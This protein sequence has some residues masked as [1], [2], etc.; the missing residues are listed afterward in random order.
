MTVLT[1]P[2]HDAA[3]G[4]HSAWRR[5]R[6]WILVAAGLAVVVLLAIG[7]SYFRAY[8]AY[9][10]IRAEAQQLNAVRADLAKAKVPPAIL[11][12]E[13]ASSQAQAQAATSGLPLSL[14]AD[15]PFL[16]RP[17]RAM[18]LA[19]DAAGNDLRAASIVRATVAELLGQSRARHGGPAIFGNGAVN[20]R[21]VASVSSG[22]SHALSYLRVARADLGQ[23]GT[24]PFVAR[25]G[26]L[27]A[28]ALAD[29]AHAIAV[30]ERMQAASRLVPYLLG[31]PHPRTYFVALQNSSD[32]RGTGGA[33][34]AY[35]LMRVTNGR[36]RLIRSG[37]TGG[38]RRAVN[39]ASISLPS[40]LGWYVTAARIQPEFNDGVNYSPNFPDVAATWARMLHRAWGLRVDG[41][42]A[43][44]PLGVSYALG[45]EPALRVPA[46]GKRLPVSELPRVVESQQYQ[47][48]EPVQA[49]L[50]AELMASVVS[51]LS[52]P[53][54]AADVLRGAGTG[55]TQK[56][57]QLWFANRAAERFV[58][59]LG[60]DGGLR[61]SSGDYLYLVDDQRAI[62][63]VGFFTHQAVK[64]NVVVEPSGTIRSTLAVRVTNRTPSGRGLVVG[65]SYPVY[66]PDIAMMNLYVPAQAMS[67][68][69][70]PRGALSSS[71]LR[72]PVWPQGFVQH[73]SQGFRVLTQTVAAWPGNP[74]KLVFHYLVPGVIRSTGAGSVYQLTIQH[75]SLAHPAV[76]SITVRFPQ[77][78]RQVPAGWSM[79]G[80]I[81]QFSGL[82]KKDMVARIVF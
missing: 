4:P 5:P 60:W 6:T 14:A 82:L 71:V 80:N 53:V 54:K 32:D 10:S 75:Q 56:H 13:A 2:D 3:E 62:D 37:E 39:G 64:Y 57:M 58:S 72:F 33:V 78:V 61:R 21:L 63:K 48:P 49:S 45:G 12:A 52:H 79:H 65:G 76:I 51:E 20:L 44:D 26:Q 27:K 40:E 17:V 42:I 46:Y 28:H 34:Y 31:S 15:I 77:P 1:T 9:S 81:A 35:G 43:I 47:L 41:V 22:L 7:Y 16:G 59:G 29:A 11:L 74:G 8:Q 55:L 69:V 24:V 19:V 38:L 36:I 68:H 25:I 66:A 50:A 73:V 70:S 30:A 67:A 18:R 23:I